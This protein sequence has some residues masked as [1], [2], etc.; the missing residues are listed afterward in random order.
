ME[1]GKY[2]EFPEPLLG[3]SSIKLSV[4]YFGNGV[5]AL[6][7]PGGVLID[8]HP[9]YPEVPSIV[10]GLRKQ[11]IEGKLGEYNLENLYSVYMLEPE[12]TGLA[13]IATS[14]ESS[15]HLR[16]ELGSGKFIFRFSFLCKNPLKIT[17]SEC[18]LPLA[19]HYTED[20]VL[21][22]NKTGKKCRTSFKLKSTHGA[23]QLWE[24]QTDFVRMH[25]I[26]VHAM[27]SG[28][29]IVGDPLYGESALLA[30]SVLKGEPQAKS[31]NKRPF[32]E[33]LLLHLDS[34]EWNQ[35]GN[36]MSVNA[37]LP[38]EMRRLLEGSKTLNLK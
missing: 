14:K 3:M 1:N 4:L 27:E 17:S 35:N 19:K 7:K 23:Y 26:R 15:N 31:N 18:D 34:V 21:V 24:A 30:A 2:I 5:L 11:I 16:N 6:E 20:R 36:R 37:P 13:L 32:Y 10:S 9:W 25:Q 12:V 28:L 38:A 29:N 8:A 33:T 22:S